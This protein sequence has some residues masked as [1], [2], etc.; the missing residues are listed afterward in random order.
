MLPSAIFP[1]AIPTFDAHTAVLP[2][3]F[4]KWPVN[5]MYAPTA[6]VQGTLLNIIPVYSV[7]VLIITTFEP[8]SFILLIVSIKLLVSCWF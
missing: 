1:A 7:M 5:S 8:T 3:I 2:A 4:P 6:I